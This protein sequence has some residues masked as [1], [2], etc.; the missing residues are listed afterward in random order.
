MPELSVEFQ[1]TPNPNAGKFVVG[2]QVAAVGTSR[3]Y[4]DAHE[5][6]KDPIARALMSIEGV[7]SIFMV[8]DFITITK[9]HSAH[10]D[11]LVPAVERTIREHL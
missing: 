7:R 1:Q 8:D 9:T 6:R 2:R 5:A 4:Y 3:S 11:T 10:W